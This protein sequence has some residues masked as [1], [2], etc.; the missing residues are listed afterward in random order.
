MKPPLR[1]FAYPGLGD[2]LHA[3]A[4]LPALMAD[5]EVWF[6]SRWPQ[7]FHDMPQLHLGHADA[8]ADAL[9]MTCG[10]HPNH[11]PRA[12]SVLGA[13]AQACG[14]P[15]GDFRL[16]I[17]AD[18]ERA[19]GRFMSRAD[20]DGRPL[21]VYRP[22]VEVA[23]VPEN[24]AHC[25]RARNP[26]ADAYTALLTAIRE[27]YFVVAVA[28]CQHDREW[29]V[30]PQ[31]APD[32]DCTHGELD[33]ETMAAL[34][35]LAEVVFCP[36]GFATILAQ[37]TGTRC[38]TV[39]GGYEDARSFAGGAKHAPWLPIE[40]LVPCPCWSADC[41]GDKTIDL[42]AAMTRIEEFLQ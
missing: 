27:R 36:P 14:V 7:V 28:N 18:W 9:P 21:L 40:P 26:D 5:R 20:W 23:D 19:A 31:I 8:P 3:R 13:M 1:L 24:N 25:K 29:L 17:P 41:P 11:V 2:S 34:F 10:Y 6:D 39:F 33:F 12:G 42:F 35:S 30:G 15:V 38:I 16:P 4:I 32:A 22:L 37:A